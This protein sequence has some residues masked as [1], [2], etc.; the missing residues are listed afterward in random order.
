[1]RPTGWRVPLGIVLGAGILTFVV[2]PRFYSDLVLLPWTA[3]PTLLLL[4]LGEGIAAVQTRRR[5]RRA[6]GTEPIEPLSVARLVAFA[7]AS[8]LFGALA[9]GVFGGFAL[10]LLD[11]LHSTHARADALVAGGTALSG[12]I[13]LGSALFL[14]YACRVPKSD[15]EPGARA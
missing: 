10:A 14:E 13:L 11:I 15:D 7:K 3:I 2:V 12:L 9:A 6:P 5:I 1:M 4:A 8:A